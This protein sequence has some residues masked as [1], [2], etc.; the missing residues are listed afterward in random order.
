MPQHTEGWARTHFIRASLIKDE[1]V[2]QY[3]AMSSAAV[4]SK[5][6]QSPASG[7]VKAAS[8]MSKSFV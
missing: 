3:L 2:C 7:A 6:M 8:K 5:Y 1:I 4:S